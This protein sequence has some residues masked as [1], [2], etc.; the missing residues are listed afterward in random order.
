MGP[1]DKDDRAATHG[2]SHGDG[3]HLAPAA[4][5]ILERGAAELLEMTEG[6]AF[7]ALPSERYPFP[8]ARAVYREMPD[9]AAVRADAQ[10]RMASDPVGAL[11]HLLALL[12]LYESN[13]PDVADHLLDDAGLT[14][15]VFSSK[16]ANGWIAA[17][18]DG[19]RS[20]LE[21]AVNARWQFRFF[22]GPARPTGVYALLNLLA[23]YG[24]VYGR[25]A[26]GDAHGLG[27]FVEDHT[28]G[29]LVCRGEMSD[30]EHTLSLA[31]M[32]MGVPAIVPTD[33]PFPLGRTLRADVLDEI[34]ESV[35]A[36]PNIRRLLRTPET[37]GLPDYCAPEHREEQ[38]EPAITWGDTPDSFYIVRRGRVAATGVEVRGRAAGGLGVIITIDAEPMDA[39]DRDTIE[40]RVAPALSAMRG[41]AAGYTDRALRIEMAQGVQLDPRRIGEVLLAAIRMEFPRL[42]KVSAEIILDE[43]AL[44][45]MAP[46]A[47]EEKEQRRRTIATATEESVD[48][49]G[50]C[51]GC[52]PFAPDHVCVLTPERPPQCGRSYGQIKTGALY[53]YDDTS[54]IH[55]SKLHRDIN[56]HQIV[57]KGRCLDPIRGEWEG[58]NRRAAELTAGRTSRIVLHSLDGTPHTGCGCFRLV[59]FK[60]DEPRPG[61]GIMDAGYEGKAPDGRTWRDLHY[62]LAGKQ[63]DGIAGSAP[64]YLFSPKFLQAHGG[65]D[66]VVWVS[67]KIADLMGDKL[68]RSVE[69]PT[70]DGDGS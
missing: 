40:R 18:G 7:G 36:T 64:N 69:H 20:E 12:E 44:A 51:V 5:Q 25:I 38:I 29:L 50:L 53:A 4:R 49:F 56:S 42:D 17:L 59:M 11:M 19:D 61:V 3:A 8:L 48:H 27:H 32:K 23:R 21:A 58:V 39:F 9:A 43:R 15:T 30:L 1:V 46:G 31:V 45:E 63:A 2:H 13:R 34:V 37:P 33:Y 68:P 65:W 24:Y 54:N 47:G 35:T 6:M 62:S 60:T 55:H 57:E 10:S 70:G 22:H 52:S 14:G 16:R 41:V 26:F 67:R 28:P 66:S